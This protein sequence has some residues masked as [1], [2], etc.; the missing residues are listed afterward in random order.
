MSIFSKKTLI[1]P[2]DN[3]LEVT[4]F[5][6]GY[7]ESIVLHIP[8]IGWGIIDSCEHKT[9][10]ESIVLPLEYLL[11]ITT[12]PHPKL[13]FV[14]LTHPHHD[15]CKGLDRILREYPGGTARVCTYDGDGIREWEVYKTKKETALKKVI[16][17]LGYVFDAIDEVVKS[18]TQWRRL[19]E[20]NTVFE[21]NVNVKGF[22]STRIRMLALSPSA[23]SIKEYKDMLFKAIP[24][25]GKPVLKMDDEGHNLVSVA[26]LLEFGNLQIIFGSDVETG[27]NNRTGW[28]GIISNQDF[29]SLWANLVK[30]S[31]HGSENG[32]NSSA[33]K[34]FC[35]KGK[36][37]ALITPFLRGSVILPNGEI[38]KKIKS[39][40]EK[41]G[42]TNYFELDTNLKKYYSRSVTN[43]IKN[44]VIRSMKIIKKPVHPGIIRVR[45]LPDG[46]VTESL[47]KAPARWY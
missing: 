14:I 6:P 8:Q 16:Q 25:V 37:F 5:G 10:N 41:V 42:V 46:T 19:N 39:V 7:G 2:K 1:P 17:G 30:V 27:S 33:W 24:G 31:H 15:H 36:P 11:N 13:A 45:Y 12:D 44:S 28:S 4:I 34:E 47:A 29:P 20:M 38:L 43:C 40:S 9:K 35:K 22:G 32:H 26:L 18:G 23:A 3:E 21:E